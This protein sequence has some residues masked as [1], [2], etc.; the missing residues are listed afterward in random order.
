MK[1]QN[2]TKVAVID[3]NELQIMVK[4][5]VRSSMAEMNENLLK[6]LKEKFPTDEILSLEDLA[7][8][9]KK[10]EP[11]VRKMSIKLG[12]KP[13]S[14]DKNSP[15][16]YILSE[17]INALKSNGIEPEWH[18]KGVKLLNQSKENIHSNIK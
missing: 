17:V 11:T 1:N 9:L 7:A 15:P 6:H 4:E 10:S 2:Q 5:T 3:P 12:F 14:I 13:R 8:R 18:Q 16:Y